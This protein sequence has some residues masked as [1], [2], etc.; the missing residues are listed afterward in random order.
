MRLARRL[1]QQGRQ[2]AIAYQSDVV[3]EVDGK[4]TLFV[5]SDR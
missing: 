5:N 3:L 1:A 2:G 4:A